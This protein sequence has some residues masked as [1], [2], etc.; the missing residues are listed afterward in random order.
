MRL[1]CVRRNGMLGLLLCC[2]FFIGGC[3]SALTDQNVA[4]TYKANA[5]WGNSIL[6]LHADHTFEQTVVRN[7]HTQAKIDGTWKL[8]MFA[9]KNK[10]YGVIVLMPFLDVEHDHEGDRV[11]GSFTSICRGPLG[12]ITIAADPNYGISFDKE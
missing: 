3:S 11:G 10:S 9:G 4:G 12:G 1:E 2:T 7:D 8:N 5:Q 6:V